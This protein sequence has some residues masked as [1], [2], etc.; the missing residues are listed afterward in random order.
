M[1]SGSLR[2]KIMVNM[3]LSLPEHREERRATLLQYQTVSGVLMVS[4]KSCSWSP[5]LIWPLPTKEWDQFLRIAMY[6]NISV[7][8]C[9]TAPNSRLTANDICSEY[10]P[11]GLTSERSGCVLC[12][13]CSMCQRGAS[14]IKRER[15]LCSLC[16]SL[17]VQLKQFHHRSSIIQQL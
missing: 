13:I 7:W 14:L 17:C 4:D 8:I 5:V 12:E 3:Y 11:G 10:G 2:I 15:S 1:C 16:S 9:L 6:E